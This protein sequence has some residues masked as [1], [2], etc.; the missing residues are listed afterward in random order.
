MD[1]TEA[2]SLL[3]LYAIDALDADERRRLESHLNSPCALCRAEVDAY[4][5]AAA[6]IALDGPRQSPPAALREK[7]LARAAQA[8]RVEPTPAARRPTRH[9]V[10]ALAIA[11]SLLLAFA[12]T[13]RVAEPDRQAVTGR[14]PAERVAEIESRLGEQGLRRVGLIQAEDGDPR[15]HLLYDYLSRELHVWVRVDP[16]APTPTHARLLGVNG[17]LLADAP[18]RPGDGYFG[19]SLPL[20]RAPAA[21]HLLLGEQPD[22]AAGAFEESQRFTIGAG[23]ER[24]DT[25]QLP[26]DEP[27][28]VES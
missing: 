10:A 15:G 28:A 8:P 5:E 13:R 20:D 23:A 24:P 1:H 4:R 22:G 25:T 6:Q 16:E 11:A 18:L 26:V 3:P 19:A 14:S 12:V 2:N 21:G 9:V 17:D 27:R 7:V